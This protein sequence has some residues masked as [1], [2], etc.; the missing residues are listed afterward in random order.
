MRKRYTIQFLLVLTT[1]FFIA[2][3]FHEPL[4]G[5]VLRNLAMSLLFGFSCG[6]LSIWHL[7]RRYYFASSFVAILAF[8]V[9]TYG[10]LAASLI[11]YPEEF[12][13]ACAVPGLVLVLD[14]V[15]NFACTKLY[16]SPESGG[17]MAALFTF[18]GISF[19]ASIITGGAAGLALNPKLAG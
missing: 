13:M 19:V 1:L 4:L 6:L 5:L 8:T 17:L 7:G 18:V 3:V 14:F 10:Y 11:M 16:S 15:A 12:K 2:L 9:A